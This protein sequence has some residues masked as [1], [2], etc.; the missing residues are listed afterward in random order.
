MS[1]TTETTTQDP[2]KSTWKTY[3]MAQG[4]EGPLMNW[5]TPDWK[6]FAKACTS[7][8]GRPMTHEQVKAEFLKMHA[9]GWKVFPIGEPCEGFSHQTGCPGHPMPE[10]EEPA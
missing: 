10:G 8:D 9:K 4:I 2:P 7:M 3:H 1:P 5:K 6:R